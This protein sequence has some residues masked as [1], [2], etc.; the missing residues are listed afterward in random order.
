MALAS[1]ATAQAPASGTELKLSV[2]VAPAFPLGAAAKAWSDAM[3]AAPDGSI[4]SKLNPGASLAQ[5]DPQRELFALRDGAADL[6]VG[7]ALAWSAQLPALAVYA[8]PWIAPER[9]DLDALVASPAVAG[10]LMRRTEAIGVVLLALAPLGHR[11]LVTT[12]KAI[13]SPA[14]LKGL[15]IRATGGPLVVESLVWLGAR[16]EAMSFAQAQDA[17]AAGRLDGQDG[18]ATGFVGARAA[19]TGYKHLLRW[20]AFGD[21]MLFAVRR[22]VWD[23]WTDAQRRVAL[24]T[25]R[26]VAAA[27]NAPAREAEA[28]K[29]L[30]A[31]GMGETRLTRA[32]H[33]A[34]AEAVASA[35]AARTAAVGADLVAT[36][37]RVVA[38]A[39][40]ARPPE[41]TAPR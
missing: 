1:L 2:A 30:V 25:A 39:R 41:A 24:D 3:A 11:A 22:A 6:A 37:E 14:D 4:A 34:F 15:R 9:E 12:S 40:A 20:G 36:A 13:R 29:V 17:L 7:S 5:R 28:E 21:A 19:A 38:D 10:E 31:L 33:V 27:A 32:G 23:G 16:P 18:M 8:I 35:R 26:K